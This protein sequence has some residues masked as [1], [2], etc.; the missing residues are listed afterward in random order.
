MRSWGSLDAFVTALIPQ[1]EVRK[2]AVLLAHI[3]DVANA[4]TVVWP[5]IV[6]ARLYSVF[7]PDPTHLIHAQVDEEIA[8]T[9]PTLASNF[10]E[11][12]VLVELGGIDPGFSSGLTKDELNSLRRVTAAERHPNLAE[13]SA[14]TNA[15]LPADSQLPNP[16]RASNSGAPP[17]PFCNPIGYSNPGCADGHPGISVNHCWE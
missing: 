16:Q 4:F 6:R 14:I 9:Q 15:R 13:P 11:A 1:D 3:E 17:S 5:T 10:T 2:Y 12:A 8:L 7:G